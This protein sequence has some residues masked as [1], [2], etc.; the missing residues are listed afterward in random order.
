MFNIVVI[1]GY[2]VLYVKVSNGLITESV[3]SG[4]G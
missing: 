4:T 1:K 3:A 2:F